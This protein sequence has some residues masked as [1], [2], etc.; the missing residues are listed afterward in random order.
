MRRARIQVKPV[1]NPRAA[2]PT[3]NNN[4]G[5]KEGASKEDESHQKSAKE[6]TSGS[7]PAAV[8]TNSSTSR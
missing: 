2:R 4:A 1:L 3:S 5:S 8:E 6:G 7:V